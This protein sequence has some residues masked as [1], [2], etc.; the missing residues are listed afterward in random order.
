MVLVLL[1]REGF[2]RGTDVLLAVAC[3]D[4]CPV[5][6]AEGFTLVRMEVNN[7][8]EKGVVARIRPRLAWWQC[9]QDGC[10]LGCQ[11]RCAREADFGSAIFEMEG[12]EMRRLGPGRTLCAKEG[13]HLVLPML[14]E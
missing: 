3:Y 11:I 4:A 12:M 2:S 13:E 7:W 10:V 5:C 14:G 9:K 6:D 1:D 8:D